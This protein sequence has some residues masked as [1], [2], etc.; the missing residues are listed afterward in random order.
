MPKAVAFVLLAII[1]VGVTVVADDTPPPPE[2]E[3]LPIGLTDEEKTRLDEI[4]RDHVSTAPPTGSVRNP[5]EWEPMQGVIIRYPFGISYDLIAEMSEDIVVTTIVASSSEQSYVTSMYQSNGVNMSNTDFLIAATNSIWTRD[6]GPWFIFEESGDLAIVDHIYNRPRPQDDVIPQH[7]GNAWGLDVY[8]M[9][10]EHTGGNHMSDG[11]GMSMSTELV[12]N[13]NPGLSHY[14]VDS[15]MYDYLGN[16][17]TVLDYIESGG[18]HHIDCWA[19][20]LSPTT[21][22]VKDVPPSSSSHDLLDDRA[23]QLS[24]MMSPWGRPYTVVRVYCPYG[25][26]YT[27]S[28]ILNDKVLVP[29]FGD[30]WDDDAIQ[31]YQDAMP[32]YEVI[33]FTGSWYD[34]DAIHCRTMGVPDSN[35][36]FIHHVPLFDTADTLNDYLVSAT[37]VDHS[38]AGLI[39]DSLKIYYSVDEG[40]WQFAMM[41]ATADPEVFEGYIPAQG[42]VGQ[43][44]YYIKAA[45]NSGRVET[46]PFIGEP[47]AHTF[48]IDLPPDM[49]LPLTELADSLQPEAEDTMHLPVINNGA[50]ALEISFSS[51][52]AWLAFD[53]AMQ[54]I[55]PGDSVELE[56]V[57]DGAGLACGDYS[58]GIDYVSNDPDMPSGNVAVDLHIFAPDMLIAEDSLAEEL[59]P[60]SSSS[61]SFTIDNNGPGRLD[62]TVACQMFSGL[63]S[64]ALNEMSEPIQTRH[65]INDKGETIEQIFA[66]P[67]RGYGG[68]DAYGHSWVDS[69]EGGGVTYDWVD[70]TG[71]GTSVSLGD[72]DATGAIPIGFAFGFYDSV[73]TELYIG[74]NG[75]VT[76]DEPSDLR[77]N[78]ELPTE[79]QKAMI[80]PFWDDLDPGAGGTIYYYSDTVNDR[81]IVTFDDVRMYYSSS[82]TGS[83]NFQVVLYPDGRIV[84]QYAVMDPGVEDLLSCTIG[85]QNSEFDDGLQVVRN[86]A[87]VHDNLAIEITAAHWLSVL[88]AGG[89]IDPYSSADITVSFD[90]T[91]MEE[92]EY[93]GQIRVDGNDPDTPDYQMPVTLVVSSDSFVCGDVDGSGSGPNVADLVYLVDWMFSDGPP[94]PELGAINVNGDDSVGDVADLVYLVTY[95]FQSGPPPQCP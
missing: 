62:Y 34:N 3:L 76:F 92:G 18:I 79:Y 35:M 36:L 82:G 17:Y 90:A 59:A 53:T 12:Y 41:S 40:P 67:T 39:V 1:L 72:D 8:G 27:N 68:P 43:I 60:D 37:I 21:I 86:A 51:P 74:S 9:D 4:G 54:T 88:P 73:Y 63:A 23:E 75:V 19:K 69:D 24:Q 64:P 15:I 61:T 5:S 56:V 70:I 44:E 49:Q 11:L 94:P 16:D 22:L 55:P 57:V 26:A 38:D 13:E 32:G 30:A 58:G 7:I 10:L 31:T 93:S 65:V 77:V 33:G 84:L 25:T 91:G 2:E 85:I 14:E 87:Y 81:F 95:M 47:W 89:S 29:I 71:V 42:G 6:Y 78:L 83:L 28:I 45:D 50:G 52:D 20:F 48:S 46:H 80:A 66:A